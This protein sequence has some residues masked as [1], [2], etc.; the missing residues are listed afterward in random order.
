MK[1]LCIILLAMIASVSFV[2]CNLT[3]DDTTG[4]IG[5]PEIV[6]NADNSVS[7]AEVNG[8][9]EYVVEVNGKEQ[10][11][12]TGLSFAPIIEVGTY[13]I[14]VKGVNGEYFGD[15][16]EAV[17]YTFTQ[18]D[19][20][21]IFLAKPVLE[22]QSDNSI[23]WE[24]IEGATGYVASV[25][26]K[27]TETFADT[28]LPAYS[29]EGTYVIK[30]KAMGEKSGIWSEEIT[31]TVR[32]LLKLTKYDEPVSILKTSQRLYVESTTTASNPK[33][34][35][36]YTNSSVN[37]VPYF[38]IEWKCYL[39]GKVT[40]TVEISKNEDLSSAKTFTTD[41]K[42]VNVYNLYNGTTY[43]Y[44]VTAENE[45]GES[46]S[47][48]SSF[49][50]DNTGPRVINVEG[51][52]N[53]RDI[54][55]YLTESGKRT[56][57]GL[58]YRG[59]EIDG[60]YPITEAGK[61]T[62]LEELGIKTDVDLRGNTGI[63]ESPLGKDV[64]ITFYP[65]GNYLSAFAANGQTELYR[66]IFSYLADAN[67]YPAYIHCQGGADRTGTVVFLLNALVGVPLENLIEDQEFTSFS[68]VGM[69]TFYPA[70]GGYD[71]LLMSP[72]YDKLMSDYEGETL[73]EKVE[74]YMLSI[75][76]TETEIYNLRAIMLGEPLKINVTAPAEVNVA[77]QSVLRLS[78]PTLGG[79][80]IESVA[81]GGK[82][83]EFTY[84]NGAIL[85]EVEEFSTIAD[86]EVNGKVVFNDGVEI[87]F[88][89]IKKDVINI[90]AHSFNVL[91]DTAL[92]I[93][94]S[95]IG[96]MTVSKVTIGGAEV[97]FTYET[98]KI[99]VPAAEFEGIAN[100]VVNGAIVLSNGKELAFTFSKELVNTLY[101]SDYVAENTVVSVGGEATT[102][103][104]G[105]G[106]KIKMHIDTNVS[107]NGGL[108]FEI[109]SYGFYHRGSSLRVYRDGAEETRPKNTSLSQS[110]FNDGKLYI[111]M[112]VE[113]INET[114]A[115][116]HFV[117]E[118]VDG[119][120][121]NN[122]VAL[123]YDFTIKSTDITSENAA[124]RISPLDA[125]E[126]DVTIL[127]DKG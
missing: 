123:Y 102:T 78:V 61:K 66:Q 85:V 76:V 15:W 9:T 75:G 60:K 48:S 70:E 94:I 125:S 16:S 17:S 42:Y 18:E 59:A 95:D 79:K 69:R 124:F 84:E 108:L 65:I 22:L 26:G 121:S 89:F 93:D 53:V 105:F 109:G 91:E 38:K 39:A 103:A 51:V 116:L 24:A 44:K 82:N 27:E 72:V 36:N 30:V 20:D 47:E 100:G 63:T 4:T 64:E 57:Q 119:S 71:N 28:F 106:S 117:T 29:E 77:S 81:V 32:D 118:T 87:E 80:E 19:I 98:G 120:A 37:V 10:Q 54:G 62:M 25:N 35:Y 6:L 52:P 11:A 2:A 8:A 49:T 96:E 56:L 40:Y 92:T 33:N 113:I 13:S 45:L 101:L 88:S 12:Q 114:T 14:R 67:N 104:I 122:A 73:S 99:T 107:G 7:W 5:K 43:Y 46:V 41:K 74:N 31:Y 111:T 115:R 3:G 68:I 126:G 21:A 50:T 110:A 1:K 112:W 97:S 23:I 86:G 34:I 83:V 127:A 55:G 58:I 90:K